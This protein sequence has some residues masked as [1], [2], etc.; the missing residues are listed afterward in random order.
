M[1]WRHILVSQPCGI[2]ISRGQLVLSLE[3]KH[4]F[5]LEDVNSLLIE[6]RQC[7]LSAAALAELGKAAVAVYFCD[8]KHLPCAVLLP[9][10][11]H[12]RHPAVAESQIK[13]GKPRKN[14][15]W[16]Q[17]VIAKIK[18]QACCLSLNGKDA[19]AKSLHNYARQVQSGDPD[20]REG[21]AAG[22]YFKALF[23]PGF[24][25]EKALGTNAALNYGYALLRGQMARALSLYGF[26]PGLGLHHQNKLNAFNLADDLMEPFRPIVDL[27]VC[28]HPF[29]GEELSPADKRALFQ[30]LCMDLLVEGK[31]QP[32]SYA[33]ELCV[34]SLGRALEGGGQPKLVLPELLDLHP[35]PCE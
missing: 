10:A 34:Q 35:H 1:G 16:Q 14:R 24:S 11:G 13:A 32:L 25:R 23:G 30:L 21:A 33:M 3:E 17:L 12:Y 2:S 31:R 26:L 18:A 20:N 27:F 4:S 7:L 29:P 6:N 15:L 9:Y 5:P 19:A 22:L 8:D 28:R